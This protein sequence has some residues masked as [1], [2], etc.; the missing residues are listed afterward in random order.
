MSAGGDLALIQNHHPVI[1]KSLK[2]HS[3]MRYP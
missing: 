2:G 3:D 1:D